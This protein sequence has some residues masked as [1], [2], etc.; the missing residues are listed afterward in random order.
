MDYPTN[1]A[2]YNHKDP[3]KRN[4]E[5]SNKDDGHET[6]KARGWNIYRKGHRLRNT[7]GLQKIKKA[8]KQILLSKPPEK[9]QPCRYSVS[10]GKLILDF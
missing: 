5:R 6:T 8:K 4:A 1:W 3:C 10:S 7:G 2:Q 9:K